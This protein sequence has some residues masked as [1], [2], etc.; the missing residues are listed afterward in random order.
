[1]VKLTVV[2]C[3]LLFLLS[4]RMKKCG[5]ITTGIF[6]FISGVYSVVI[7]I[8]VL[9][10]GATD[11]CNEAETNA[12]QQGFEININEFSSNCYVGVNTYAG[13]AIGGGSL[14]ILIALFVF[15]FAC[16]SRYDAFL[17]ER[18]QADKDVVIM[19]QQNQGN[20][21]PEQPRTVNGTVTGDNV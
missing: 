10:A 14:W 8:L 21:A 11:L 13:L 3:R 16:G 7:G 1:M 2:S 18:D 6:A 5:L 4:C 12:Q 20:M 9:V 19:V 15:V 17:A